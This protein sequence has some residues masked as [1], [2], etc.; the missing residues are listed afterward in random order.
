MTVGDMSYLGEYQLLGPE[1]GMASFTSN[2]AD[3]IRQWEDE[4]ERKKKTLAYDDNGPGLLPVTTGDM[5]FDKEYS[6]LQSRPA[7]PQP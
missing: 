3:E 4:W 6:K 2:P 1:Q 5:S 7:H